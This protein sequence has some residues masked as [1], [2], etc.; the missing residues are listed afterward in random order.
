M[1]PG[2]ATTGI[3]RELISGFAR[4]DLSP[5]RSSTNSTALRVA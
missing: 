1:P 3:R 2:R 4:A 5:T